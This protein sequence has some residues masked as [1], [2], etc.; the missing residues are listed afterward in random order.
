MTVNEFVGYYKMAKDKKA[1]CEKH[2]V[3]KYIPFAVKLA[4]CQSLAKATMEYQEKPE[5]APRYSQNTALR[6]LAFSIQLINAYTDFD[7][8]P[9]EQG[10]DV[11]DMLKTCGAFEELMQL[12]PQDEVKEYSTLLSMCVDDY[13]ANN[14]NLISYFEN[15]IMEMAQLSALQG[16]DKIEDVTTE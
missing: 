7:E 16:E 14:R 1:E 15:K 3:K 11:Y 8:I 4:Q 9:H 2:I 12:I 10:F 5:D 13:L 6:Y